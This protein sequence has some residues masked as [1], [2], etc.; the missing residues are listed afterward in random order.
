MNLNK[1]IAHF[2]KRQIDSMAKYTPVSAAWLMHILFKE[3]GW[4]LRKQIL[5][6]Y[7]HNESAIT[8]SSIKESLSYI[9]EKGVKHFPLPLSDKYKLSD[10]KICK[11][12]SCGLY[13]ILHDGKKLYFSR[14]LTSHQVRH[15]YNFLLMEQDPESPHCY[16]SPSFELEDNC[17]LFDIGAAEAFFSLCMIDKV[18]EVYIFETETRWIEALEKTFEPWAHKVRIIN[19]YVSDTDSASTVKI[20]S[21]TQA[22]SNEKLFLKLDVE[23]AERIVIKGAKETLKSNLFD[24]KTSI[25]TYHKQ[26]DHEELSSI[27]HNLGYSTETSM[28]YMLFADAT[29]APPFFRRGLIRCKKA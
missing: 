12:D 10:I 11:D 7:K 3:N 17:I 9:K 14:E 1:K 19:K 29:F 24:I 16:L 26:N 15:I 25:C 22:F 13:Y 8:D 20:D 28:N 4:E 6:Y 18:K 27:M 23:G 5:K 2:A 21:V